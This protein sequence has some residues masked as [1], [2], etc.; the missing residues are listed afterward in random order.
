MHSI[1]VMILMITY[2]FQ[3]FLNVSIMLLVYI[4]MQYMK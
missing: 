4:D 3:L 1:K 2:L